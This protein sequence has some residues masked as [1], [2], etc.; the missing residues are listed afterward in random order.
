MDIGKNNF[1]FHFKQKQYTI[2]S[3]LT[4]D[5]IWTSIR[6]LL[7][8]MDVRWTSKECCVLTG[9]PLEISYQ[10]KAYRPN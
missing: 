2:S 8:V 1:S 7:N 10:L 5:V 9:I 4:Q 6:R 3:L